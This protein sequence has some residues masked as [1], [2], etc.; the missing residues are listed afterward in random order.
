[1]KHPTGY[2]SKYVRFK[3]VHGKTQLKDDFKSKT[4]YI[5]Q[6]AFVVD[7]IDY[8]QIKVLV[9]ELCQ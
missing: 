8:G 5:Y 1:M 9:L 3:V 6:T 4:N 2:K 7:Q